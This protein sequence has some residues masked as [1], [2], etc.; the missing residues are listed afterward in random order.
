MKE[1]DVW[2]ATDSLCILV[3]RFRARSFRDPPPNTV[4]EKRGRT[5]QPDSS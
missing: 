2:I 1:V 4:V 3:R 5:D